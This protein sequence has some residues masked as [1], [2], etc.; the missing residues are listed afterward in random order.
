MRTALGDPYSQ[1]GFTLL[2]QPALVLGREFIKLHVPEVVLN[3]I[4]FVQVRR[5]VH[6]SA[7]TPPVNRNILTDTLAVRFSC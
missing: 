4:L 6:G 2:V 7:F 1:M 5:E 3:S